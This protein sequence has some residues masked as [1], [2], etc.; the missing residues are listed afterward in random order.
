MISND[1]DKAVVMEEVGC[2][3]GNVD[4][5]VIGY[6]DRTQKIT[7][8]S[9]IRLNQWFTNPKQ[10]G[11]ESVAGIAVLA[12]MKG[13]KA[14]IKEPRNPNDRDVIHEIFVS[15]LGT[16]QLRKQIPNFAYVFSHFLCTPSVI[17]ESTK[18]VTSFCGEGDTKVLHTVYEAIA[19]ATDA[20]KAA[21]TQT[22]LQY[23][24]MIMQIALALQIANE[25][26]GFQHGDL[27]GE[28][29][30]FRDVS[31]QMRERHD[32]DV[33]EPVEFYIPYQTKDHSFYLLANGVA[34][35]ID[36]GRSRIKYQGNVYG[37]NE[38]ALLSSWEK[39]YPIADLFRFF[40][41]TL[42]YALNSHR[43]DKAW[44]NIA[45]SLMRFFYPDIRTEKDL[46]KVLEVCDRTYGMIPYRENVKPID[47][48]MHFQKVAPEF[49]DIIL[50]TDRPDSLPILGCNDAMAGSCPVKRKVEQT[51]GLTSRPS[52]NNLFDFFTSKSIDNKGSIKFDYTKAMRQHVAEYKRILSQSE[53]VEL[54][55]FG[56][57]KA[58]IDVFDLSILKYIKGEINKIITARTNF[59]LL[60]NYIAVGESVA[61]DYKDVN[62]VKYFKLQLANYRQ[63]RSQLDLI[64]R[65][66]K[67]YIDDIIKLI[68]T[69]KGDRLY[70]TDKKF[71]WYQQ[72]APNYF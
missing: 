49:F 43:G 7:L 67:Q 16:N 37:F 40:T 62:M 56:G 15:I 14:V 20:F 22:L 31:A 5:D 42:K 70:R 11:A 19:P 27:H 53:N 32:Y 17:D 48:V 24:S 4:E 63:L 18:K 44:I 66:A 1:F 51:L 25:T 47:F 46:T 50:T 8:D 64:I 13:S 29:V 10:I 68:K 45:I 61:N 55:D 59:Y 57:I 65:H 72:T 2:I 39:D 60:E 69:P 30:L 6:R 28:N 71:R 3:I 26:I 36:F 41:F 12:D 58:D 9:S 23:L 34:T 38:P 54:T 52:A 35:I 33:D 21:Q